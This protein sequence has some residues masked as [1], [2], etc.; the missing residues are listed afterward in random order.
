MN[1][2]Q[3]S[4][5]AITYRLI[6]TRRNAS[7]ILLLTREC[8]MSL[9]SIEIPQGRRIAESLTAGLYAQWGCRAYCLLVRAPAS[10]NS[11][12]AVME[13][14]EPGEIAYAGTSWK[15]L[16]ARTRAAM[17]CADDRNITQESIEEL[18]VCRR[19]PKPFARPGWLSEL[20]AWAKAQLDPLGIRLTGSFTQLNSSPTFTLIR[21][22]TDDSAVWFKATGEPNRHELS[23]TGCLAHLFPRY[24]PEVLGVHAAWNGWLVREVPGRTLNDDSEL[25]SWL[26][27][28]GDLARVQ[29]ESIGKQAELL[30]AACR[31]LRLPRLIGLVDPFVDRMHGLMADQQK[32]TPAR[33]TGPELALLRDS[34]KQAC[35]ELSE[36]RLPDT[37][38]HLDFNPGNVV[39]SR[40]RCVFLDWAEACLTNPLVTLEHLREHFRRNRTNN[41]QTIEALTAAYIRVWQPFFSTDDLKKAMAI[42]PLVAVFAYAVGNNTWRSPERLLKPSFAGY[43]RCLTRRM[44]REAV[45]IGERRAPCLA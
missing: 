21:L 17:G 6:V 3:D 27:T 15:P 35:C 12:Y 13:V 29:T 19:E 1:R 14:A 31:D 32:Q 37:L 5:Q 4:E 36:R 9:P 30:E 33:L 44:Y 40:E 24:V 26:R 22:E 8:A 10:G 43:F 34:L 16:N 2:A 39:V 41:V 20:L 11:H 25:A 18:D 23:V 45:Q 28:A 7:E 42:S 38:G